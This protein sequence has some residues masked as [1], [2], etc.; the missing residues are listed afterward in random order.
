MFLKNFDKAEKI[1]EAEQGRSECGEIGGHV[2]HDN[3]D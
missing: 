2:P 3:D 1:D